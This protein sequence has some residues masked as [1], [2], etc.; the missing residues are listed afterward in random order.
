M[1]PERI[2][3]QP[4]R[5][6]ALVAAL[7]LAC[8]ADAPRFEPGRDGLPI[9]GTGWRLG[10]RSERQVAGVRQPAHWFLGSGD[11]PRVALTNGEANSD[12]AFAHFTHSGTAVL[13]TRTPNPGSGQG[14]YYRVFAID[15]G[16]LRELGSDSIWACADPTLTG[17]V[18]EFHIQSD[19]YHCHLLPFVWGDVVA[20]R[21]P[22]RP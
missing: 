4:S 12:L 15:P 2:V 19:P 21:V 5:L 11:L 13:V 10:F 17:D 9:G 22:L 7:T 16:R 20:A 8:N 6:L 14:A 1:V 18:L 3:P